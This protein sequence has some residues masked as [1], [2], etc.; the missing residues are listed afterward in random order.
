MGGDAQ[1]IGTLDSRDM[2]IAEASNISDAALGYAAVSMNTMHGSM[3]RLRAILL[4]IERTRSAKAALDL[5]TY[6]RAEVARMAVILTRLQ[7]VERKVEA[8]RT[9]LLLEAYARDE[10]YVQMRIDG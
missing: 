2:V 4:E 9:A 1:A 3:T 10:L 7:A 5:N 8:A 6:A